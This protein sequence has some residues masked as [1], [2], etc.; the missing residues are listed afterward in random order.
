M[1]GISYTGY[2]LY[3][4]LDRPVLEP[5]KAIPDRTAMIIKVNHPVELLGELRQNNLIWKELLKYPGTR[6]V[7]EQVLLIDSMTR[8]SRDIREALNDYPFY[9]TLSFHGRTSFDLLFL[10][11]VP[12]RVDAKQLSGFLEENYPGKVT[13]LSSPYASTEILR[14]YFEQRQEPLSLAT[15]KGVL[16]FSFQDD[17]VKKAI[18]QLSLNTPVT[19]MRGFTTVAST[20]GKKV[21]ANI[22]INFP[23]FSLA[24]WK[25]VNEPYK[26]SLVKFAQFADWCGLDLL[27]KKDELLLNG[28]TTATDSAMQA[29]GLLGSQIPVK[30]GVVSI[31]PANLQ[32][33]FLYG[34]HDYPLFFRQWEIRRQRAE[35]SMTGISLFGALNDR[36]D[37]NVR[38]FLDPWIGQ[39]A[40]RCWLQPS[41]RDSAVFPVTILH[42]P[43]PDSARKSL[44]RLAWLTGQKADS[45]LYNGQAIYRT[46]L[47]DILNTWLSPMFRPADLACFTILN[48]YICFAR[49]PAVLR[50]LLESYTKRELLVELPAYEEI[51]G[52]ISPEANISF[53]CN[54]P[55]LLDRLSGVLTAEYSARIL[56][57]AD[58]LK[59]F[60]SLVIQLSSEEG[61]YYTSLVV[62][63]NPK[64]NSEGPLAWQ[65]ALDTLVTGT[66]RI[67][68]ENT[69][70]GFAVLVT[71]TSHTLYK[72]DR[73]GRILWRQ[74][75][76][77]RVLGTFHNIR[78]NGSDSLFY[79]F[80]TENHLYLIRS[81]GQLAD[82]FPLKF[83]VRASN[84]LLLADYNNNRDYRIIVAFRNNKVYNFNLNGELVPGWKVPEIEEEVVVPVVYIPLPRATIRDY[85]FITGKE[86]TI[87][88]TDRTGQK[89]IT[90]SRE[91]SNSPHSTF[92][93]NRTNAKAPFLTSDQAGNVV[94]LQ[95][96]GKTSRVSFNR[97]TTGHYFFYE[98]IVGDGTPEF[99]FFDKNTLYYYNRFFKLIYFYTFRHDVSPPQLVKT[100][101]GKTFIG[102]IS[103]ATNEVFLFDRQGYMEIESGVQGTTPFDIGTLEEENRLNLL[104]GAGKQVKCFRLTE[105]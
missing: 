93:L 50:N 48:D 100:L 73:S 86:G 69:G 40:G 90:P 28:Y 64:T 29:L 72:I 61:M 41:P 26:S 2:L 3:L 78:I 44:L 76:Y 24:I 35:F 55:V 99:I 47:S 19:V 60:R 66:P 102:F 75:L 12:T 4:K 15:F 51:S 79:L 5:V 81:D 68:R 42:T 63:F 70:S 36:Y 91:F 95:E 56:P 20:T 46:N 32:A 34:F 80:N 45:N 101:N 8:Q 33:Y 30:L 57:L 1:A 53:Y 58:S 9:I 104:I 77:G 16:I 84:G 14:A 97:F 71:D 59:K 17:L 52:N 98:D 82:R 10:A 22:F 96:N 11:S 43:L 6:E 74:K 38:L 67:I 92:Y 39:Q 94:Y 31:L 25:T 85:F 103:P 54:S 18:D 62:K 49:D 65:T 27:I 13:I 88:I 7:Q 23:Y 37:T 87:L 105:F 83:P 21:D 89:R